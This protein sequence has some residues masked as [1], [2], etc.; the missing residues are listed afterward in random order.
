MQIETLSE[1][2]CDAL[3]PGELRVGATLWRWSRD[4][5]TIGEQT[6]PPER[7]G[8]PQLSAS[9]RV[10]SGSRDWTPPRRDGWLHLRVV[11]RGAT[12]ERRDL[13]AKLATPDTLSLAGIPELEVD[14]VV[15]PLD[16]MLD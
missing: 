8:V 2:E 5:L 16:Q 3:H 12:V 14:G 15:V 1:L 10:E 13:S 4:G 6:W 7:L 11:L 9:A